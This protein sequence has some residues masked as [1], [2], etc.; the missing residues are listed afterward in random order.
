[1]SEINPH[2]ISGIREVQV[3]RADLLSHSL[4]LRSPGEKIVILSVSKMEEAAHRSKKLERRIERVLNFGGENR[5]RQ[6][7]AGLPCIRAGSKRRLNANRH[8]R[9][10]AGQR[11]VTVSA[12]TIFY[13]GLQM[14]HRVG[15]FAMAGSRNFGPMPDENM[16]FTH[17]YLGK[18]LMPKTS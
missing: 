18:Q 6:P 15:K 14:K 16:G 9:K 4:F 2:P 8:E 17:H 3:G 7:P 12:G 1:M 5:I 13:I 10:P 11:I